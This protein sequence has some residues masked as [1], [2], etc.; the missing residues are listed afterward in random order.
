[1]ESRLRKNDVIP[2]E[3]TGMSHE[4]NG[5][6]R[7]RDFVLFVPM[8][9]PGDKILCHVVKVNHSFGYGRIKEV[10][11]PSSL[12]TENDCPVFQQ[13]G[14]CSW[15]HIRYQEELLF[16][17]QMVEQNLKKIASISTPLEPI[18]SCQEI[19]YRNKAQYPI[20]RDSS[21]KI[22]VGFYAKRS[23]RIVQ[24]SDCKLQPG[25][26]EALC[27]AVTEWANQFHVTIY[28]EK[29]GKGLL[30]HLYLRTAQKT[31]QTMVCLVAASDT[32]PYE[33]ELCERLLQAHP[34]VHTVLIN[35]NAENTNVILG[36]KYRVL[37]GP[38]VVEDE[39]CGVRIR[40]SPSAFYQVNRDAAE[41]MYQLAA[42]YAQPD[43]TQ[44]LLDLYCGT[45]TIGLTMANRGARLI[46][47]EVVGQ[48]V[49]DAR[50]N[51]R[52]NQID[53][54][55]FLCA[56]AGEAAQ[57]LAKR[58]EHP[59]IIIVDP[60]RKGCDDNT[61]DAIAE[62][63]PQRLVYISCNSATLARDIEKLG[64]KGY[65]FVKG[66]PVDLFPRTSH[67]ECVVLLEQNMNVSLQG[68]FEN[69]T[70]F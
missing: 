31:G 27:S 25:F 33:K 52:R 39:I 61:L 22:V 66:R 23:H 58:G 17:Q 35:Q 59:D 3:I 67:V 69:E 19:R 47:V 41:Q 13:C 6:G 26:F 38:G 44:T 54:T 42:D 14:G 70:A 63:S 50:D 55:E 4:G 10:L 36:K 18:L 48:A 12:R 7:Y 2:L 24:C 43:G 60:P 8:T 21:G 68:G 15:R 53:N 28:D 11:E 51:A 1:M 16:K 64:K 56:D 9:A 30:R 20:G 29:T 37:Y 45:G 49:E 46:G 32:L 34:S 5:V 57:Q 62:M 40:I 65:H